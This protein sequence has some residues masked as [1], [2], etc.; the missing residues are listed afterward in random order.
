MA[1]PASASAVFGPALDVAR[2][3]A[4]LLTGAAVERGL[5][6]PAEA[7]RIWERHLLN[8]AVVADLV[9]ERCTLADLG[10]GAGL[11]GVVLAIMRPLAMVTLVEPMARR[12]AFLE[13]CVGRLG[14]GNV[15][16]RRGRAEDLAGQVEADIVTARAVASLDRLAGLAAGLARPGGTVLAIKGAS[17]AAELGRAMPE[18]RRIGASGVELLRVGEG[19]LDQPTTVVRFTTATRSR[20]RGAGR[21]SAPRPSGGARHRGARPR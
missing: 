10:S 5:I 9:P 15:R 19:V 6:G 12:T 3:Y 1:E 2:E 16:V 8:S 4:A 18:L 21:R 20:D 11:P 7:G 14:L 17:A 13:E